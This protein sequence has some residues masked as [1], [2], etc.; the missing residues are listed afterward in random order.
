MAHTDAVTHR[1]PFCYYLLLFC[2]VFLF[3]GTM[4]N[5][6]YS[7]Q[8][9]L[10]IGMWHEQT[11]M[12]ECL[13]FHDILKEIARSLGSLCIVIQTDG[14][15][16]WQ[17]YRRHCWVS[18]LSRLKRR[19]HKLPLRSIFLYNARS[20]TNKMDEL[21]L[22]IANIF[23]TVILLFCYPGLLFLDILGL[24]FC[25]S[26]KLGSTYAYLKQILS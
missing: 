9:L 23:K 22:Q 1:S 16:R 17:R 19:P 21:R 18:V 4:A 13:C 5:P 15:Q 3:F 12:T 10:R 24:T 14:H 11:I 26:Q 8:D 6:P 20:I 2:Y 7:Q 25:Y